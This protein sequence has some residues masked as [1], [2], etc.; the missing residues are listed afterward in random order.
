MRGRSTALAHHT[1]P[2]SRATMLAHR[3]GLKAASPTSLAGR[4]ASSRRAYGRRTGRL[5]RGAGRCDRGRTTPI[6]PAKGAKGAAAAGT[7]RLP[8]CN[9]MRLG[10]GPACRWRPARAGPGPS[11]PRPRPSSALVGS[12]RGIKGPCRPRGGSPR[13]RPVSAGRAGGRRAAAPDPAPRDAATRVPVM[14]PR[15]A[16]RASAN[17]RSRA[18]GRRRALADSEAAGAAAPRH[19]LPAHAP[20]GWG[21]GGPGLALAGG[22]P[23]I[24]AAPRLVGSARTVRAASR[25]LKAIR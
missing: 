11:R 10:P 12:K 7:V 18:R 2:E 21:F 16:P 5:G 23:G 6:C 22:W 24:C 25:H 9:G 15:R 13:G 20:A 4:R 14:S 8:R 3:S 1:R 19:R 17:Q